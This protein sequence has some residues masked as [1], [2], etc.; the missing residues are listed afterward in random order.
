MSANGGR[1]Y[2]PIIGL[3]QVFFFNIESWKKNLTTSG[4]VNTVVVIHS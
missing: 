4:L 1:Y 3:L 2:L